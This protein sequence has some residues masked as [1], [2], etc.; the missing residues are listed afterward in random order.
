MYEVRKNNK[1]TKTFNLL[2]K[3]FL[4]EKG[5]NFSSA[6]LFFSSKNH[7]SSKNIELPSSV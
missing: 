4:A 2:I 7:S 6:G 5:P 1:V 3:I